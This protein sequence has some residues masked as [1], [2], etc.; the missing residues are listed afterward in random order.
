M[1]NSNQA[2]KN[3]VIHTHM[4]IAIIKWIYSYVQ[5]KAPLLMIANLKIEG[6][7]KHGSHTN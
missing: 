5:M 7:M 3:P 2:E 4:N 6:T 1:R